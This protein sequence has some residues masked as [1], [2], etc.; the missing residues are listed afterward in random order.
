MTTN[1]ENLISIQNMRAISGLDNNIHA[2]TLPKNIGTVYDC[3][4]RG[5]RWKKLVDVSGYLKGHGRGRLVE[6]L[7]LMCLVPGNKRD[8]FMTLS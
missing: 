7:E 1:V 8:G 3:I 2:E 4:T 5:T 6:C